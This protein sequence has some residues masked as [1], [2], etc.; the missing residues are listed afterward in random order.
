VE[1]EGIAS[2]V[3]GPVAKH[4]RREVLPRAAEPVPRVKQLSQMRQMGVVCAAREHV[5]RHVVLVKH[6]QTWGADMLQHEFDA[7][8]RAGGAGVS[9]REQRLRVGVVEKC[10]ARPAE[11][12]RVRPD[13]AE[14]DPLAEADLGTAQHHGNR[15]VG[16]AASRFDAPPGNLIQPPVI[17]VDEVRPALPRVDT[18][19]AAVRS[20]GRNDVI[21]IPNGRSPGA[22]QRRQIVGVGALEPMTEVVLGG[23]AEHRIPAASRRC[24]VRLAVHAHRG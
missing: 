5:E 15:F 10:R 6:L 12:S 4:E 2:Y 8:L 3:A 21:P 13:I 18:F 24:V 14:R 1:H 9:R 20:V 16:L 22:A 11:H 19:G 23:A 17:P 7:V